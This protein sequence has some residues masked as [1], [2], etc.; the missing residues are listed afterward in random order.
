LLESESVTAIAVNGDNEKWL[1]TARSGIYLM[2]A[3]GSKE[4]SHFTESNSPLLSNN[5]TSVAINDDGNVFIGTDKGIVSFRD[6]KVPARETLDSLVIYPSPVRENYLGPVYINNLVAK[7]NIKITDVSGNLI[8]E[9]RSEG[10][11]V[12][13]DGYSL[14]GR[15]AHTGVYLVFVTNP[16]GS[17]KKVAKL[18]FI[19]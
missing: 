12:I 14:D 8:Y 19:N 1:G 11:Q 17:K 16:D 7:S 9:T 10:A 3:D 18:L 13:W 4:I 6:Y 15:R 2:S 5:I